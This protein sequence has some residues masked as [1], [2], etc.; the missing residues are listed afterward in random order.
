[1]NRRTFLQTTST[2]ALAS[3][4]ARPLLALPTNS[5]YM[6]NIGLQLW[7][8][9]NQLKEDV[10]KTLKAVADAG[11]KQVELMR[12]L[13]AGNFVPVAKDNGLAVTSAFIDWRIIGFKGKKGVSTFDAVIEVGKKHGLKHIV[14]GYIGK[15]S[16]ETVDQ[17][18]VLA[19]RSNEAG[20]A[21]QKA[22][23]QLCYHNHSFE[24]AKLDGAK[25][26]FDVFTDEFDHELVKFEI[27]VFWVGIGGLNPIK[28]LR[29]L[30][31]RVSQVHLKDLKQGVGTIHDE[32]KVPKDAFK[33]LGNGTIDM[34]KVLKV[35][36]QIGVEQ[37]HVEQ[38]QSPNPIASIGTSMK[39]LRSI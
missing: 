30:K 15:G 27:D 9:R 35:S 37:C 19:E 29:T 36:E 20:E 6:K 23:M 17:Y 8:V 12:T 24:F 1:M 11:Y 21:C 2:A 32:G 18:K 39:H 33:E 28:T 22:G 4:L 13:D 25:T 14:F 26:G 3:S 7:T 34:A 10:P 16:R 38:D 31:G 5:K